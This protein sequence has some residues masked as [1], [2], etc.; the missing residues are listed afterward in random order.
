MRYERSNKYLIRN[1]LE[2]QLKDGDM[3]SWWYLGGLFC[4]CNWWY[5]C[6]DRLQRIAI[7]A[8]IP[9]LPPLLY[10]QSIADII[11][12]S[13]RQ[14][15]INSKGNNAN[16]KIFMIAMMSSLS[17]LEDKKVPELPQILMNTLTQV[18]RRMSST[19]IF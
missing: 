4:V 7:V 6:T 8:V 14:Y 1:Q 12:K 17:P 18:Y 2:W 5:C 19:L 13:I 10:F 11:L 9:T 3:K 15:Q 16:Y